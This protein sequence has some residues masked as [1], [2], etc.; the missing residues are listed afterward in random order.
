M[1]LFWSATSADA[2]INS[3]DSGDT[4][5]NGLTI[6][7]PGVSPSPTFTRFIKGSSDQWELYLT[8]AT[9]ASL[10]IGTFLIFKNATG[11]DDLVLTVDTSVTSYEL[12]SVFRVF[13]F[14]GTRATVG[15]GDF[16]LE[17]NSPAMDFEFDP[18]AA[19]ATILR[20]NLTLISLYTVRASYI[21]GADPTTYSIVGT[22][23]QGIAIDASSGEITYQGNATNNA[24][25]PQVGSSF[26]VEASA[27]NG[28]DSI[29][30]FV[31]TV[32]IVEDHIPTFGQITV[33]AFGFHQNEAITPVDLP[34][35]T[36]GNPPLV[37]LVNPNLPSGLVL[38][39]NTISG[40]PTVPLEATQ[41]TWL[42]TD[43]DGDTDSVTFTLSVASEAGLTEARSFWREPRVWE[44]KASDG[45]SADTLGEWETSR[46]YGQK[47]AYAPNANKY[48]LTFEW[49]ELLAETMPA[50]AVEPGDIFVATKQNRIER[51]PIGSGDGR[52]YRSDGTSIVIAPA[53]DV[54]GEA[55]PVMD[56]NDFVVGGADGLPVRLQAP[57][58]NSEHLLSSVDKR[59]V[60]RTRS[61]VVFSP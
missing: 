16:V 58:S 1:A 31:L 57:N 34:V 40:T 38:T 5:P 7:V 3:S 15:T 23:Q 10:P 54:L 55:Y 24:A 52:A 8:N 48:D 61:G 28:G 60:W 19:S 26:A 20:N 42:V 6:P 12:A 51:L 39:G 47:I 41:F 22:L 36:S 17:I 33:T 21:P 44:G 53:G 59:I 9:S 25:L 2:D 49:S 56:E 14:T 30:R 35:A 4:F 29:N 18:S 32:S 45:S 50:R 11:G 37:Y 43:N 46:L 27:N 13:V